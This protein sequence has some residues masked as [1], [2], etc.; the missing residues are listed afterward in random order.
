MPNKLW[1][2]ITTFWSPDTARRH[3]GRSRKR[4]RDELDKTND[5]WSTLTLDREIWK[6]WGE[7]VAQPWDDAG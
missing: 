3:R 5:Q 4:W 6:S 7:A 2:K 1:A